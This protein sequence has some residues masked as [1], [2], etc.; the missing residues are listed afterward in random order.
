MF[1]SSYISQTRKRKMSVLPYFCHFGIVFAFP[2]PCRLFCLSVALSALF[3]LSLFLCWLCFSFPLPFW[4]CFTFPLLFQLCF[5]FHCSFGFVLRSIALSALF[6]FPLPF[7]L[8]F[9][10]YSLHPFRFAPSILPCHFQ[11]ALLFTLSRWLSYLL[12]CV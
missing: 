7:R 6:C 12:S 5:A 11:L 4:L 3:C 1:A 9:A 10:F 2:L 8:C